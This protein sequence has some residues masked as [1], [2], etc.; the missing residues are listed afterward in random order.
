MATPIDFDLIEALAR[1]ILGQLSPLTGVRAT[2]TATVTN[3]GLA[4]VELDPNMY[5][6]P[7]KN[8]ELADD[9]PFKVR[10]NPATE[11]PY[12]RGGAWTIPANGSLSV[13]VQSNLGGARHNL[14][15][16]T[17]LRFDPPIPGLDEVAL[18]DA[19]MTDGVDPPQDDVA[20]RRAVYY[21]ELDAATVERDIASGRLAQLPG[22]MLVWQQ[23]TPAEGRTAGTNQGSTRLAS[24][25]RMFAENYRLFVVSASMASSGK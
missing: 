4:A 2:G 10:R 16:G 24:G 18:V 14:R 3:P 8:G 7:V 23:S 17:V 12:R 5:L 13:G 9:L 20:V 1:A 19:D 15:A 25:T 22:I 11:E 6:L 21:E